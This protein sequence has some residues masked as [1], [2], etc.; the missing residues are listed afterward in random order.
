MCIYIPMAVWWP[1]D[2]I[3]QFLFGLVLLS[4][5]LSYVCVC[6]WTLYVCLLLTFIIA[7]LEQI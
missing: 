4:P 3:P 5:F 7:G 6:V 2:V 1:L